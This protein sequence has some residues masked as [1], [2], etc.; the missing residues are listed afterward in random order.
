V[1]GE[2]I[3]AQ[4]E[5]FPGAEGFGKF[6][7]GGRGG[8]V[9]E[10]TNLN[11][12]GPGSFREAVEQE[13]IRTVIFRISG[14]VALESELEIENGD[15][16]IAGQSAPGD[17]ICIKNFQTTVNA[18]NVIIRFIRFRLGDEKK[19][20]A[21]A[22]SIMNS[23]NVI[24]DHC[25]LSWGIDEVFSFYD[26]EN[27]T[28]QWCIISESLHNSFHNKGRHGYGGIW[29]GKNATFHHNLV[30]HNSSRNPRFNGSRTK[31]SHAEELVDFRNNVIYN[32][33][34]NSSYGGEDASYNIVNN[35]YKYGPAT[36]NDVRGRIIEPWDDKARWYISGN[37]VEGF[38]D[39][40][41]DNWNGGVQ[42]ENSDKPGIKVS[43]PFSAASIVIESPEQAYINVLLYAGA[44]YPRRDIVDQRI[45]EDVRNCTA[46]FEG[47]SYDIDN[48]I[49]TSIVT[50]IIDSQSDVGGWPY[51]ESGAPLPDSDRDGMPDDWEI[52]MNLNP[53]DPDDRNKQAIS[54]YTFL[55]EYLNE[56]TA[57]SGSIT[58]GCCG[59][60]NRKVK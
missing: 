23:R 1:A 25:S 4:L 58:K 2:E 26:N 27:T 40:T 14:T 41:L 6:T 28:M 18:D 16:T 52:K 34:F 57:P 51:L 37:F 13:G 20:E 53:A 44:I 22:L 8:K 56:L 36:K 32:W 10:V 38:A 17:G 24:V 30:A 15:L 29:G 55:E 42:G 9:I 54:G 11:D 50:G 12:E 3:F 48:G 59:D 43:K 47:K 39:I 35:Y 60:S 5:A 19:E 46:E 31:Y 49:D 7:T 21:D 33:G 45:V